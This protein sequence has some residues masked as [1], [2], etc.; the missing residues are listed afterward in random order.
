MLTVIALQP[1]VTFEQPEKD[2]LPFFI[3]STSFLR[4][5][6]TIVVL[7][8]SSFCQEKVAEDK[9]FA[10]RIVFLSGKVSHYNV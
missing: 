7:F 6:E 4:S 5:S 8:C 10:S 3:T 9:R 1:L 2:H